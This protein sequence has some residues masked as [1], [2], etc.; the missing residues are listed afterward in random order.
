[1]ID[2]VGRI[3]GEALEGGAGE[4]HPL[5]IGSNTFIPGFEGL[6]G[7]MPG[8]TVDVM[9]FPAD[10]AAHLA[11]K[12]AVFEVTVKELREPGEAKIDDAFAES[13]GL[14]NLPRLKTLSVTR[15][16][17]SMPPPSGPRSKYPFSMHSMVLP[18][19]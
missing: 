15:S 1:M 7:A 5:G 17:V 13:L 6:V 18:A 2:F 14:E 10:Y 11:G 19:N 8:S 12:E 16:T 9:P 3:D 4:D